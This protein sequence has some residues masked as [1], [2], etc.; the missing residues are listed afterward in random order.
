MSGIQI[1]GPL[2]NVNINI[3]LVVAEL[4]EL[5]IEHVVVEFKEATSK[6]F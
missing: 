2:S 3:A 6:E 5:D 4:V 1:L